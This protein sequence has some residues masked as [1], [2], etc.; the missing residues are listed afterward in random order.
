MRLR[1]IFERF[2]KQHSQTHGPFAIQGS[3]KFQLVLFGAY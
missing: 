1:I 3:Y 2:K